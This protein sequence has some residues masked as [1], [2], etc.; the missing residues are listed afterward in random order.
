LRLTAIALALGLPVA[1]A[2]ARFSASVLYGVAPH[3]LPT[4]TAVP[5]FLLLVALLACWLPSR[6]AS[7][8]NPVEALRY[9]G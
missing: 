9:N 3:D 1:F 6:R 5:A 4:F 8:I 2:L 7:R